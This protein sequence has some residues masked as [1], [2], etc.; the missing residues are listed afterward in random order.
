MQSNPDKHRYLL[1]CGDDVRSH[2][3]E[4]VGVARHLPQALASVGPL[5]SMHMVQ[6][7]AF[8]NDMV[9]N[10]ALNIVHLV[11]AAIFKTHSQKR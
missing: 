10:P 7:M 4:V 2:R 3:L 11:E 5:G 9:H 1:Q 6:D 8:D